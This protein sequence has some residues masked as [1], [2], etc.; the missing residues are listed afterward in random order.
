MV[1]F[2]GKTCLCQQFLQEKFLNDHKE[3][4]DEMHSIELEIFPVLRY[5][6]FVIASVLISTTV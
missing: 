2:K 4:V 6:K 3:T 1:L 5:L